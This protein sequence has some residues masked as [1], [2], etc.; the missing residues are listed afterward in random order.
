MR[1]V[2]VLMT[3]A[4]T[5]GAAS[6]SPTVCIGPADVEVELGQP[7]EM[8]VRVDDGV[9]TLTCFLVEFSFD[10]GTIELVSA[11]EGTLFGESGHSTMFDWDEITPGLHSCNDVTLGF[12]AFVMC[13]GE[14]VHLEFRPLAEGWTAVEITAVD[15]R[16]I[17]RDPILPVLTEDAVVTVGPG[18]GVFGGG[19]VPAAPALRCFPN[20]FAGE[21][22]IELAGV[23]SG[24]AARVTVYDAAGR[25]VARPSLRE[26]SRHLR[27]SVWDGSGRDGRPVPGGVYF[28]AAD[29][30]GGRATERVTLAR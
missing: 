27:T 17:R 22:T 24:Q 16:D 26:S 21:T 8:S 1:G 5:A 9:D 2:L 23:R 6:S 14:L 4:A 12:D 25:V 13:P 28:V 10:P 7:F 18:T 29:C 11:E 19:L 15:L 20:P 3:I 30:P